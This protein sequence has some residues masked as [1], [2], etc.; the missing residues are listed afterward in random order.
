MIRADMYGLIEAAL[1]ACKITEALREPLINTGDGV[2]ALVRPVDEVSTTLLLRAFAPAL[3]A[4]LAEHADI[5][6]N[7]RFRLRVAIHSGDVHFDRVGPF[8]EDVDLTFR[9]LN[10]PELKQRLQQTDSPLMLAVSD[11]I[12]RSVIRQGYNGI[13][14]RTFEPIIF[15]EMAGQRHT[16]WVRAVWESDHN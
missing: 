12:H 1:L 16:G 4:M 14:R 6:P 9:L 10:A 13:D 8:S 11:H 5:H 2:L 3:S 7:R 15:F